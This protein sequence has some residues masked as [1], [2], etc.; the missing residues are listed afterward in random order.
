MMIREMGMDLYNQN[1]KTGWGLFWNVSQKLISNP[2]LQSNTAST[3][4][5]SIVLSSGE[6]YCFST[7]IKV[8]KKTE[9]NFLLYHLSIVQSH[10]YLSNWEWR[11]CFSFKVLHDLIFHT[12]TIS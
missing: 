3:N 1:G 4:T 9:T 2:Y 8:V 7:E 11:F 5:A 12:D 6:S 10:F